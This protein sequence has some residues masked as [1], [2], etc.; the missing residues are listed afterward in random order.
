ML[1]VPFLYW[2]NP[3]TKPDKK[4]QS[5]KFKDAAR[6]AEADEDEAAFED[7]LKRI[8]KRPDNGKKAPGK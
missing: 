5:E 3:M 4:S 2:N 8:V 6:E 1:L 7:K